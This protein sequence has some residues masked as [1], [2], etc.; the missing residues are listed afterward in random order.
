[1]NQILLDYLMVAFAVV[2]SWKMYYTAQPPPADEA[3]EAA[4]PADNAV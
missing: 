4:A 2:I 3:S 1:M